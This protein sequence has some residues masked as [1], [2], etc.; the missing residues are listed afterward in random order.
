MASEPRTANSLSTELNIRRYEMKLESDEIKHKRNLCVLETKR[1]RE[2]RELNEEIDEEKKIEKKR[3]KREKESKK[4][5]KKLEKE[6]RKLEKENRKLERER[7][8][9]M[10]KKGNYKPRTS[11]CW[12]I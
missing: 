9:E 10:G 11:F 12:A 5:M 2:E 4:E 3:A 8:K 6:N 1:I 7:D